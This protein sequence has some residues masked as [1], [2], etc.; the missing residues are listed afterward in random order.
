MKK[1]TE[2]RKINPNPDDPTWTF[3]Y[4]SRKHIERLRHRFLVEIGNRPPTSTQLWR[5][6]HTPVLSQKIA[7]QRRKNGIEWPSV[8][9]R[10][11]R[12]VNDWFNR[13]VNEWIIEHGSITRGKKDSL[14]MNAAYY[15]RWVLTGKRRMNKSKYDQDKRMWFFY[16][17]WEKSQELKN[18]P[19]TPSKILDVA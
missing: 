6:A 9:R 19:K 5:K 16:R 18:L 10:F 7:Q 8:P 3:P 17:D 13:K 1:V 12:Q 2:L 11:R 14:R 4:A 15:G